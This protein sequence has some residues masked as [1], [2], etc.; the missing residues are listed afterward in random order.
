[1]R[2][3][4]EY[5]DYPEHSLDGRIRLAFAWIPEKAD[6]LLDGGCAWGYGTRFFKKK[7]NDAYGIDPNAKF[8]AIAQKRYS[9]INF[10]KSMLENTPFKPDSFDVIILNDVIEHVSDEEKSL[11]EVFRILK[12]RGTLVITAPH[13]GLFSFMDPD[14]HVFFLR[15]NVPWLYKLLLRINKEEEPQQN[16]PGYENKH[17]HYSIRDFNNVLDNSRFKNNYG[18]LEVFRSGL[19]IEAFAS[20]L[21]LILT[22]TAGKKMKSALMRPLLRLSRIDFFVPYGLLSFNIALKI[23]KE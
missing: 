15:T 1:M 5:V 9:H 12:P 7:C 20:M 14:N 16:K 23:I 4:K 13:K 21:E 11:N 17:R 8:I 19:F 22:F 10:L 18:L 6:T 3:D 2:V